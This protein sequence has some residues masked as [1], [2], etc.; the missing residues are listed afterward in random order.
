MK[1]LAHRIIYV[2]ASRGCPFTCEFCLSS[3]EEKVRS[4]DLD[5]FLV[6]MDDLV[7]RGCRTFKFVDRTFNLKPSTCQK[8][9]GFFISAGHVRR[10][11]HYCRQ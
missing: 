7:Q 3:I 5:A 2:E 1:I 8:I 10:M 4:F 9:L 6:A 11:A